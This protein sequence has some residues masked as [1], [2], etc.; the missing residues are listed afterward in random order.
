ML[1]AYADGDG[2]GLG[3]WPLCNSGI[4]HGDRPTHI[5]PVCGLCL[6]ARLAKLPSTHEWCARRYLECTPSN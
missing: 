4:K 3:R 1:R 6:I 2:I 5:V